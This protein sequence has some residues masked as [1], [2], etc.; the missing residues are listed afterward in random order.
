MNRHAKFKAKAC[1]I[2][3]LPRGARHDGRPD[4]S[5]EIVRNC[6]RLAIFRLQLCHWLRYVSVQK[7][8]NTFGLWRIYYTLREKDTDHSLGVMLSCEWPRPGR[9]A[10]RTTGKQDVARRQPLTGE[11]GRHPEVDASV[12]PRRCLWTQAPPSF[13]LLGVK[14]NSGQSFMKLHVSR[15]TQSPCLRIERVWF[16]CWLC[17]GEKG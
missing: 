13:Y 1:V 5:L 11:T 12:E 3:I 4:T 17:C 7:S 15:G 9:K 6:G 16:P 2:E 14:S 8:V 10:S